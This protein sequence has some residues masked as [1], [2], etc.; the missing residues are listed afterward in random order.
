MNESV[1]SME[2][3]HEINQP[4]NIQYI[5]HRPPACWSWCWCA[6][7]SRRGTWPTAA[8]SRGTTPS[9]PVC[10]IY[11][12][13]KKYYKKYKNINVSHLPPTSPKC[14][15][16]PT[17][18]SIHTGEFLRRHSSKWRLTDLG[19]QQAEIAGEWLRKVQQKKKEY[20]YRGDIFIFMFIAHPNLHRHTL[21]LSPT[22]PPNSNNTHI[23]YI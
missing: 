22:N 14:K 12:H 7:G 17:L 9:I 18:H 19:R 5:P 23:T 13:L 6:T 8:R 1:K 15:P 2:P 20:Y 21:S 4:T 3:I 11:M 16:R 10:F